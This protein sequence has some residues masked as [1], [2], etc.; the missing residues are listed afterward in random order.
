M[1]KLYESRLFAQQG[2]CDGLNQGLN[3]TCNWSPRENRSVGEAPRVQR[4]VK[5]WRWIASTDVTFAEPV[6]TE[7]A[8]K[9]LNQ[10]T[11]T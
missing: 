5:L 1:H 11:T 3:S 4:L 2:Q 6:Q 10:E 7:C 8:R 9:S